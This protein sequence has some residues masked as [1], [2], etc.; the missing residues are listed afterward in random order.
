MNLAHREAPKKVSMNGRG[1]G[2]PQMVYV[3]GQPSCIES[4]YLQKFNAVY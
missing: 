3:P 4:N 2:S 1:L